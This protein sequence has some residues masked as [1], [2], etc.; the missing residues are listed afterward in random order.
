LFGDAEDLR[1]SGRKMRKEGESLWNILNG[2]GKKVR[3]K[4]G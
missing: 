4:E 3:R 2:I 1:E